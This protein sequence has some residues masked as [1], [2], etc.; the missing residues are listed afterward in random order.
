MSVAESLALERLANAELGRRLID[1][2]SRLAAMECE[3]LSTLAEFDSRYGWW[4]DGEVSC[5]D[6]LASRCGLSRITAR[7]KL[8]VAHEL[9]RRPA[10]R[11]AFQGGALSYSKVR[12]ITRI[13]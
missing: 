2:S 9:E 7:E 1:L 6:W 13:A 4:N 11:A 3:W 10:V 8:R 5:V 12:A